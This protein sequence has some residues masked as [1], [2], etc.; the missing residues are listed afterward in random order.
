MGLD[1]LKGSISPEADLI[2]RAK[3]RHN[4]AIIEK[5]YDSILER[6]SQDAVFAASLLNEGENEYDCERHDLLRHAHL[7]KVER[8]KAQVQLGVSEQSQQEHRAT[9]LV[10]RDVH[11]QKDVPDRFH[12]IGQS[13]LFTY[14]TEIYSQEE[15]VD[16]LSRN[17]GENLLMTSLG[18]V[19]VD[20]N[21]PD[22]HLAWIKNE[23]REAYRKQIEQKKKQSERAKAQQEGKR[24]AEEATA[25]GYTPSKR[26]TVS[27]EFS[28]ESGFQNESGFQ[29]LLSLLVA[30]A[31][32]HSQ[33][34]IF[35]K[36]EDCSCPSLRA[37]VS[38]EDARIKSMH[39]SRQTRPNY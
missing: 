9:R 8:T 14:R 7:P 35:S 1:Q 10:Y 23:N 27:K 32:C 12:Y 30:E 21:E 3:S 25:F 34:P 38:S 29:S 2:S 37:N 36:A 28:L 13:W 33:W 17:P 5:G 15:Y 6:F 19:D 18:M 24:K 39:A 11:D 22:R 4:R 31:V 20:L 16:F 26:G